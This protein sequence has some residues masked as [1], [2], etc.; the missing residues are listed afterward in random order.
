MAGE[1]E[2]MSRSGVGD[3]EG[4]RRQQLGAKAGACGSA[5]KAVLWRWLEVGW[6]GGEGGGAP[7]VVGGRVGQR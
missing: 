5:G 2:W 7:A 3:G 1:E 6:V 4:P